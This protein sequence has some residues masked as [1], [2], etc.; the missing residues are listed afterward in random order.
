[1]YPLELKIYQKSKNQS[2]NYDILRCLNSYEHDTGDF[3]LKKNL[4]VIVFNSTIDRIILIGYHGEVEM[5]EDEFSIEFELV[6]KT[7]INSAKTYEVVIMMY[8]P[9]LLK[10]NSFVKDLEI[11]F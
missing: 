2:M 8:F 4:V 5:L 7:V 9:K 3:L 10:L 1:M 6:E 11:N